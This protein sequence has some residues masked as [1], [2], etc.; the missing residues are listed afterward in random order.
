MERVAAFSIRRTRTSVAMRDSAKAMK[1][2]TTAAMSPRFIQLMTAAYLRARSAKTQGNRE[3]ALLSIIWNWA[4][5][6]GMTTPPWPAAGMEKSKWKNPEKPRRMKVLDPVW[7]AIH[8]EGNQ[9]LRDC[10]DLGSATG[11]RLMDCITVLLPRGDLLHLEASKTGKE[12]EWDMSLSQTL[13]DLLQCRRALSADHLM[14]LSTPES[15]PVKYG[16]CAI[17]GTRRA[18]GPPS[19]PV[20]TTTTTWC[21]LFVRCTFAMAGNAQP[22]NRRAWKPRHSCCSMTARGSRSAITGRSGD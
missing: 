21:G 13:P 22:R 9:T 18:S 4:R 20:S 15:Q 11:M 1:S 10:M 12:A 5:I 3:M 16:S 17:S 7:E 19:K 8:Y 14:L 2:G 6:E